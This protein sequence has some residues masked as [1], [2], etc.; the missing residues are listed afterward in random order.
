MFFISN[1]VKNNIKNIISLDSLKFEVNYADI[2][3]AVRF[4]GMKLKESNN[5]YKDN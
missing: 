4:L 1:L 2:G 3:P 5:K